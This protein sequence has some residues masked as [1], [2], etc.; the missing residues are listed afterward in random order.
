M[1]KCSNAVGNM[2]EDKRRNQIFLKY[3]NNNTSNDKC[4]VDIVRSVYDLR[5]EGHKVN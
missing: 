5:K 3:L 4:L 2:R 1:K